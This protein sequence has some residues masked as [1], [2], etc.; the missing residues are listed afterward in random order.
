MSSQASLSLPGNLVRQRMSSYLRARSLY[1]KDKKEKTMA[2]LPT[3]LRSKKM[4]KKGIKTK[5]GTGYFSL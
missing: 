1:Q 4:K 5:K 3:G 2:F